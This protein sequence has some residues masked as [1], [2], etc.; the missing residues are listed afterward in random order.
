MQKKR[1]IVICAMLFGVVQSLIF[2]FQSSTIQAADNTGALWTEVGVTKAL[3]YNLSIDAGVEYRTVDWF[4]WSS[5]WSAGVGLNYKLNKYIKFGLSY[6]FIQKHY[7]EETKYKYKGVDESFLTY[8]GLSITDADGIIHNYSGYN[9]DAANWA[10]RHRLAL[11]V[12]GSYRIQ[13]LVRISVRE[14]YQYTHQAARTV[15]RTKYRDPSYDGDD[16]L[17]GFDEE[18]FTT[19]EKSAKNRHLLRS[20]LKFSID[21]KGWKFEPY[22]S[23]ETH[24][25]LSSKMH[26]DKIRTIVGVDYSINKQHKVGLGYVF[27]HE[28]DDDGDQNIHAIS[29]GYNFKF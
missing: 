26:L 29:V 25:D 12:S 17:T 19:D 10:N 1:V 2:K 14:R 15:D 5:R 13:K 4:D 27:N 23:A 24:N 18:T 22:I 8:Q 3:P 6:T 9:V 11:D 21:K 7:Q 20:R 28:N 16:N